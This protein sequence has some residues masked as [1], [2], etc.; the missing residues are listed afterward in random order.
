[1]ALIY[2]A[3]G[4]HRDTV[5]CLCENGAN[6]HATDRVSYNRTVMYVWMYV[7]MYVCIYV[8]MYI[9]SMYIHILYTLYSY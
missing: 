5:Q 8:C 1:M 9:I 7:W 6:I 4:G 3:K 2:A